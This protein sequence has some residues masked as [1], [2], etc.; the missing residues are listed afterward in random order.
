M[1]NFQDAAKG[2]FAKRF[3]NTIRKKIRIL[4]KIFKFF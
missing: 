2:L 4:R 1:A 3:C